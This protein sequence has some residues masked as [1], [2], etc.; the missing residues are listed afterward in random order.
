[1]ANERAKGVNWRKF[2]MRTSF[3]K[4]MRPRCP[5]HPGQAGRWLGNAPIEQAVPANQAVPAIPF[6]GHALAAV[7]RRERCARDQTLWSEA[8]VALAD[9]EA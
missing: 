4:K 3:S 2:F 6:A 5:P 9:L 1:M 7:A 8:K